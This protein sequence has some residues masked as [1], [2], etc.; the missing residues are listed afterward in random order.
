[1]ATV[2]AYQ[3]KAG[4]T[5]FAVRYR[6]PDRGTTYKRGFATRRAAQAWG[7]EVEVNKM[8]GAY[9]AP[10]L[11]RITVAELAPD[12]LALHEHQA[13]SHY[14]TLESAWRVHV[15]PRWGNV[16]V[17]DID[18]A[19]IEAWIAGMTR[20]GNGK[21]NGGG[22]TTV[23]RANGVLRGILAYAVKKKRL[24]ANP[25]V[26]VETLPKKTAKRRVYLTADDVYR[27]AHESGEHRALVFVLAYCGLRWGEAIGLHV[28]DIEFLRRRLAVQENAVQLGS[29]HAVGPVKGRVSRWV[30]VP[31]FVLDDL[32][33]QCIGKAPGDLVFPGPDGGYLPRPK[34][35][36]GWFTRAVKAA[37]V[38]RV[39]P[40]DLRHTCASLAVSAGVNVLALQRMLGHK[41]A[42]MTLDTYADLFDDDLD[43]VATSLHARYSHEIVLKM[44]SQGAHGAAQQT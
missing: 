32:S 9:I 41:S 38:Q 26:G 1:M 43:D 8:A 13:P 36:N 12:W 33:R 29:H 24:A 28:I 44:R 3:N 4:K 16:S 10:A 20:K 19:G 31:Q 34:S 18:T 39:T 5:L 30:P 2:E 27:L 23:L 17:A 21:G 35:S 42:K 14:R 11:G 6:K 37:K 15:Q 25:A 22:A 7:N 40:H